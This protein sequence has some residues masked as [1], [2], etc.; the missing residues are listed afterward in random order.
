[1]E[2]E[3][4]ATVQVHASTM[5]SQKT[6]TPT[7]VGRMARLGGNQPP[8]KLSL[9]IYEVIWKKLLIDHWLEELE[10]QDSMV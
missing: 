8:W 7:L 1:M 5:K 10:E 4:K 2:Q 9:L 6:K 3:N